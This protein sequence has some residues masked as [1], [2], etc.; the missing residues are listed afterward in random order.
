ML[1]LLVP[2]L[3]T[4]VG[5]GAGIGAAVLLQPPAP[6][7]TAKAH[8]CPE[9]ENAAYAEAMPEEAPKGDQEY[10][11][12]NNQFVVPVIAEDKISALIVI[13]LSI[14]IGAGNTETVYSHE[15][16]LRDEFLQIMF[17]HAHAGGFEGAFTQSSSLDI[18]RQELRRASRR[19][20]GEAAT[21]VLITEIAR[22]DAI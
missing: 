6:K 21:D 3:L 22:Q 8:D 14:E 20:L 12:L 15:P 19:I 11:K 9:P 2:V 17:D 18:L 10:V 5:T 1:K 16:K 7:E 4:V 13:G